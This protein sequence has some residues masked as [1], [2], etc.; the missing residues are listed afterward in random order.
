MTPKE[1]SPESE[2][3]AEITEDNA[4]DL[5]AGLGDALGQ[6]TEGLGDAM[7]QIAQGLGAAFGELQ[8]TLEKMQSDQSALSE[9]YF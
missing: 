7:G 9:K 8:S 6:L 3:N 1:K 2:E 4:L 5:T